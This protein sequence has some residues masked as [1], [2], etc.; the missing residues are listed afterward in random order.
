MEKKY[1]EIA[2]ILI[3]PVKIGES[4]F[5]REKQGVRRTS[6]VQSIGRISDTEA[7]FETLNTHYCVRLIK[8]GASS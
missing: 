4:A 5:I 1:V 3:Y 6:I 8:G 7:R 2:G